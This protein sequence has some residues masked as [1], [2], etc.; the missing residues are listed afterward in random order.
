MQGSFAHLTLLGN[1]F[2]GFRSERT[3]TVETV[4][5]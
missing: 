4:F 5:N 1:R 3:E 2:N